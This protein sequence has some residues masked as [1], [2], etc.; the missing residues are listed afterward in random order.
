[1]DIQFYNTLT[2]EKAKFIPINGSTVGMYS[3]GPTVYNYAHIGNL[4]SYVFAD[5]VKRTLIHFG[6]NVN[7]VMNITDIGHLTSDADDGEDKMMKGLRREG[8]PITLEA[9]KEMAVFYKDRF[10]EDLQSLNI[11]FPNTVPFASD[12]IKEEAELVEK[13]LEKGYAYKTSDTIYF[14]VSKFPDYWNLSGNKPKAEN[15][16]SRIGENLEKRNPY[17]F[18]LWKFGGDLGY[19]SKIGTGFP[20]WHIE[21]SA[22]SM[23]YLGE[24][25]DIHTGGI[26][27][28][29]VH[30]TNEIAQSE[31]AT[32]K[33][34]FAKVW[35]HHEHVNIGAD[36]MAKSGGNFI[37]LRTLIEKNIHP[38]AYRLW[39]LMGNYRTQMNF[40]YESLSGAQNALEKLYNHFLDLG[41]DKGTANVEYVVKFDA[42]IAD[43]LNTPQ[44]TALLWE[45]VKDD[46][47]S[48]ADKKATLLVFDTV[49]GLGLSTLKKDVAPDEVMNLVSL[50]EEA[51]KNKDFAKSDEFRSKILEFGYEVKDTPDGPK[52]YKQ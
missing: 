22:M 27:H 23:K 1:M 38:I 15:L 29:P 46:A 19:Q 35:M 24:Q 11:I 52:V 25:L 9:M 8:K 32:G 43:D 2:H 3:C 49:L 40:S 33:K 13:L 17:D 37:T 4:R 39:L 30:H 48:N 31:C 45:L 41:D 36:K 14:D 6:Y 16:E 26:D 51:R 7:H 34:P 18:A 44:A 5:T 21:C 10:M 47:V 12:H 28:I 50:R 42:L 20:G